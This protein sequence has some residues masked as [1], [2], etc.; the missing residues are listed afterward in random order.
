MLI[1]VTA[2]IFYFLGRYAGREQ[3]I[4]TQ[5]KKLSRKL[6]HPVKAGVIDYKLPEQARYEA[7]EQ[8]KIDDSFR[9]AAKQGGLV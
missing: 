4:V 3:E 8:K 5:G 1:L 2:I 7:S 6:F 9:E